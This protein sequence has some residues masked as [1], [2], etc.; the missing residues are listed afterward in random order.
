MTEVASLGSVNVDRIRYRPTDRITELETTHSWFPTA[1]ETVRIDGTPATLEFETAADESAVGGKGANQAVAAARASADVA[2]FGCVGVDEDANGICETL[3]DRG[4]DVDD[5]AVTDR[6]TGKAYV[7]VDEMGESWIAIVGGANETLD[8]A[9]ID[10]NYD[11]LQA[12]DVLL[13]QNEIPV[14]TMTF[15][16]ERFEADESRPTVVFN[17]APA[18]GAESLLEREAVDYV[19]VNDAEYRLLEETLAGVDGTVV[20][21]R[22]GDDVILTGDVSYRATPP[23]ADPIDT[24]GAGDAFC[25]YFAAALADGETPERAV[26]IAA[27]AGSVA[28]EREGVQRAIPTNADVLEALEGDDR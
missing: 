27:A 16:L 1:G 18:A 6:E 10:A 8:R 22:G 4:V 5:V 13:L 23:V 19:V 28:T 15:L 7:F 20:R 9:Y 21:T 12:V 26:D 25:G 2:L 11:R 3:A 17:A 24:T 14:P